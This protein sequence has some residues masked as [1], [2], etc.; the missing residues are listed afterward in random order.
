MLLLLLLHLL[1]LLPFLLLSLLLHLSNQQLDHI[2]WQ[3]RAWLPDPGEVAGGRRCRA[4]HSPGALFEPWPGS[5]RRVACVRHTAGYRSG[6]FLRRIQVV[7]IMQEKQQNH[8]FE[9]EC[10]IR[11]R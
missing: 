1:L 11:S 8:L 7:A 5:S 9:I 10:N 3:R 6:R 4:Q 2:P